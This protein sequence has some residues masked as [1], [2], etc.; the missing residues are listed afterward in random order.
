MDK[1][2]GQKK[3][4]YFRPGWARALDIMFRSLHIGVAG[5]MLGGVIFNQ[6]L[7]DLHFWGRLTVVT[8]L[9]LVAS[10]LYQT[11]HWPYQGAGIMAML[12]VGCVFLLHLWLQFAEQLLWAAMIIGATGSH[13]PRKYRHWSL[14]HRRVLE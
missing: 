6:P 13:M 1:K 5:V 11:R 2:D 14:L 7:S 12:H 8:G 9:G 3:S 4:M 10:E